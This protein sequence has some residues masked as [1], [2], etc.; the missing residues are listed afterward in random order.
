MEVAR[1]EGGIAET[2]AKLI[3]DRDVVGVQVAFVNVNSACANSSG[4]HQI[5][6][7]AC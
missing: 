7:V 1:I 5:I 4:R 6:I 2:E 3:L